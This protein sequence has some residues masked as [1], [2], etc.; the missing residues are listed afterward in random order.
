MSENNKKILEEYLEIILKNQIFMADESY[1]VLQTIN[2]YWSQISKDG[3]ELFFKSTY[4][5]HITRYT[6]SITKLFDKPSKKYK[7]INIPFV[8]EYIERYMNDIPFFNQVNLIKQ[9]SLLGYE[10]K[11][12]NSLSD[13]ELNKTILEHFKK[14]LPS[15]DYSGDLLLSK[16]LDIIKIYR[17][18]HYS[19]EE[20]ID[21]SSLPKTT[22][23]EVS[24]L[25]LYAK[26]FV[27]IY[28][29]AYFNKYFSID[30]INFFF[31]ED[32]Q[33][34]NVSFKRVL[35]KAGLINLKKNGK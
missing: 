22:F 26:Q 3:Y 12:L 34:T 21:F 31:S 30:G 32:A 29:L 25:L 4:S 7:T 20:Y 10:I 18:K 14:N 9:F 35:E 15:I 6:L 5:A 33:K 16:T 23:D 2:E 27:S 17:D 11:Y 28:F 24:N 13:Y 1:F 19:H 8:L